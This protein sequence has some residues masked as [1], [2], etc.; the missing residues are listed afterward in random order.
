MRQVDVNGEPPEDVELEFHA[1]KRVRKSP[2]EREAERNRQARLA[3]AGQAQADILRMQQEEQQRQLAMDIAAQREENE[4]MQLRQ[5]QEYGQRRE[6]MESQLRELQLS[7]EQLT[8]ENLELEERA[9]AL[10]RAAEKA[11][12]SQAE[13]FAAAVQREEI[14]SVQLQQQQENER[15]R[16]QMEIGLRTQQERIDEIKREKAESE[17]RIVD[18]ERVAEAAR[19]QQAQLI[20][21][22]VQREE[23][24]HMLLQQRQEFALQSE[25]MQIQIHVQEER[26]NYIKQVKLESEQR[27]SQMER[28][29]DELRGLRAE[30][31]TAAAQRDEAQGM[32]IQQQQEF[33]QQRDAMRSQ[34]REQQDRIDRITR[35]KIESEQRVLDMERVAKETRV[36]IAEVAITAA[37]RDERERLQQEKF[38]RRRE[39]MQLLIREQQLHIDQIKKEKLETERRA[40]EMECVVDEA[41]GHQANALAVIAQRDEA[42]LLLHQ[43]GQEQEQ[44]REVMRL[45]LLDQEQKIHQLRRELNLH[46]RKRRALPERGNYSMVG[47]FA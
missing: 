31:I 41:R 4:C 36:Q 13:T 43:E 30:L 9:L 34:I 11:H 33:A 20:A 10:E 46:N 1:I 26:I 37:Q 14:E 40:L 16:E 2:A 12:A 47:I 25:A 22:V 32:R 6:E 8:R 7:V 24:E 45:Q 5:Q 23:A 3:T 15:Q 44:H 35:E 21:A 17:Q 42:N 39:A 27:A 18:M 19:S 38:K 29:A 28:E